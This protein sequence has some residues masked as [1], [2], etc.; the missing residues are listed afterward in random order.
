MKTDCMQD[1]HHAEFAEDEVGH[2][3]GLKALHNS[4]TP[5]SQALMNA[6]KEY[7]AQKWKIIGQKVGKPPKVCLD[8]SQ[9]GVPF[10]ADKH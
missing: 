3:S 10:R 7:E 4:P 1:M 6:I 5:Q 2:T 9:S 8:A